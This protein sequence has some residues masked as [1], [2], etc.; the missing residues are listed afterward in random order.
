MVNSGRSSLDWSFSGDLSHNSENTVVGFVD[1]V[2]FFG[3]VEMLRDL[4]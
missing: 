4:S 3:L 2:L 1:K